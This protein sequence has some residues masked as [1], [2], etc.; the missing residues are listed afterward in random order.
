MRL[1]LSLSR[2]LSTC[3]LAALA[4]VQA[5]PTGVLLGRGPRGA[6]QRAGATTAASRRL[7]TSSSLSWRVG[8][9]RWGT[10]SASGRWPHVRTTRGVI[11]RL[12]RA[13]SDQGREAE[14]RGGRGRHE[15][16][17]QREGAPQT[18]GVAGRLELR[19]SSAGCEACSQTLPP[20]T[21]SP[22]GPRRPR[23]RRHPLHALHGAPHEGSPRAEDRAHLSRHQSQQGWSPAQ[24]PHPASPSHRRNSPHCP[25]KTPSLL[26]H[27]CALP[28]G[29][30]P[31]SAGARPR[32]R[33]HP[34]GAAAP[35][36]ELRV[37]DG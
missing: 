29:Q 22:P 19:R 30:R 20:T 27:A 26:M 24:P 37:R 4:S 2:H 36:R 25:R 3:N 5:D 31:I 9:P 7:R 16:R 11:T 23:A 6:G 32:G 21:G 8:D 17:S 34:H 13:R 18:A 12:P 10:V 14:A 1:Q 33:H 35:P 28:H 15:E